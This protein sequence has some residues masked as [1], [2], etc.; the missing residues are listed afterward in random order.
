MNLLEQ[1][2]LFDKYFKEKEHDPIGL[3]PVPDLKLSGPELQ[4]EVIS[5]EINY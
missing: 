2:E 4:P 1:F 3:N 5:E